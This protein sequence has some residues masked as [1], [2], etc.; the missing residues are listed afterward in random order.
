MQ[1]DCI[2]LFNAFYNIF[3]T[4]TGNFAAKS[5]GEGEEETC[6]KID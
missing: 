4:T 6:V 1:H 5:N 3:L 2:T